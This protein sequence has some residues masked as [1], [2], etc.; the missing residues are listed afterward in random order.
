MYPPPIHTPLVLSICDYTFTHFRTDRE[1]VSFKGVILKHE[2]RINHEMLTAGGIAAPSSLDA[3]PM[4][5]QIQPYA[6]SRII[7]LTVQSIKYPDTMMVYCSHKQ[8][9]P[10][11]LGLLPG[12]VVTMHGFKLK[13]SRSGNVYCMNCA[14]SSI[15][16]NSVKSVAVETQR[17]S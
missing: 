7:A 4:A 11:Q 6:S 3:G 13:S 12:S 10:L 9:I 8:G 14:S 1:L 2:Y 15:E 16:V 5:G 17:V